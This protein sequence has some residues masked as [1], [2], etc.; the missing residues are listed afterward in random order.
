MKSTSIHSWVA[1]RSSAMVECLAALV[2]IESGS[3]DK[4][5][6]DRAGAFMADR[7]APLGF[8]IT[9]HAAL[10]TGNPIV[11]RREFGGQGRLLILGHLDTVWP[12]GTLAD[13]P[14]RVTADGFAVGP[15][16]GDMKGGLVVAL[17]ALEA[18]V[19][20]G[21]CGLES[22]TVLLVPD[23]E[24]GSP[25]SRG[26]IEDQ[27]RQADWAFVMEPGRE[28]GG[29]VT[30]RAVL[31]K[32]GI[33]AAGRSAHCAVD[34]ERGASAVRE[35]AA[36]VAPLEALSRPAQGLLVNVG[37]FRG[38]EARQVVPARAEMQID[39]RAPDQPAAEGLIDAVRAIVTRP[40]NP[41]VTTTIEGGITR[42]EFPRSEGTLQLYRLA[43]EIAAD[44]GLPIREVH[45]KGGSDGSLVAAL[46]VPTLDGL[47]PTALEDCSRNERVV[48]ASLVPRAVLLARLIA[49]LAALPR[50]RT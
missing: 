45:T 37:L 3:C 26:L 23:E 12:T 33:E 28:D 6:V 16:V 14:F 42:P 4:A 46:G 49:S 17:T 36:M 31:G 43:A 10:S 20:C 21:G 29:V 48:V 22:V 34:W 30:S 8:A 7:L 38:G 15:G 27:G 32:F 9:R 13:W 24:L 35:L 47:G 1:D 50:E 19:H 41:R 11:A 18:L 39:F 40:R 44:L 5:G 2:S 25:H